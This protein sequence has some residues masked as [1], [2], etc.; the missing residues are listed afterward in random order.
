MEGLWYVTIIV[1]H[2]ADI[3]CAG[4]TNHMK[5]PYSTHIAFPYGIHMK[6]IQ[7]CGTYSIHMDGIWLP[8]VEF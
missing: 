6:S 7:L 8:N 1:A 4:V 5:L 3:W 2:M